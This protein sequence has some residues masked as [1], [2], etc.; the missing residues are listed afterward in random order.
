MFSGL[1]IQARKNVNGEC[2][3]VFNGLVNVKLSQENRPTIASDTNAG[4]MFQVNGNDIGKYTTFSNDI[5]LNFVTDNGEE[6]VA[7]IPNPVYLDAGKIRLHANYNQ[8][9]VSLVGT[10]NEFWVRPSLPFVMMRANPS[11]IQLRIQWN[12]NGN[13]TDRSMTEGRVI[14]PAGSCI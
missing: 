9:S 10:S 12:L 7:I 6:S 13:S 2:K 8:G 5:E 14:H 11:L 1:K 4:L 3:G